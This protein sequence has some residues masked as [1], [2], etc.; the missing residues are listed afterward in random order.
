MWKPEET[1]EGRK[2]WLFT[3]YPPNDFYDYW[4]YKNGF[5]AWAT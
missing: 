1:G 2:D 5:R 3:V 4:H